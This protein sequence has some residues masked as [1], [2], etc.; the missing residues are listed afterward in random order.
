M[1]LK[2]KITYPQVILH[3]MEILI[4]LANSIYFCLIMCLIHIAN[5]AARSRALNIYLR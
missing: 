2:L 3:R 5:L 1:G 4:P